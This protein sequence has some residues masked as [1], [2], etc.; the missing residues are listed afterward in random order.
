MLDQSIITIPNGPLVK[1]EIFTDDDFK[2]DG[3]LQFHASNP[4]SN[5][6]RQ[7]GGEMLHTG[8]G[9][10]DLFGD[11]FL[12]FYTEPMNPG[13]RDLARRVIHKIELNPSKIVHGHNGIP[14]TDERRFC[15]VLILI[16]HILR[17]VLVDPS[18]ASSLIPGLI[19]DC[20]THWS[21]IEIAMH[22]RDPQQA[23][24]KLMDRM[25]SP[26][27]RSGP[28]HL[29]NTTR[30]KG[31][32]V[33]IKAYDKIPQMVDK[34]IARRRDLRPSTDDPITRLEIELKGAKT[35]AF[36][37]L[38]SDARPLLERHGEKQFL[39]GFS[40]PSLQA[41]HRHYFSEL[42]AI[43]HA[44]KSDVDGDIAGIAAMIAATHLRWHTPVDEL[45]D[46][47]VELG[48]RKGKAPY[49]KPGSKDEAKKKVAAR[50][51]MRA[52]VERFLE[53]S[54][55][56]TAAE[57]LS[58]HAYKIQ[59]FVNVEGRYGA[60]ELFTQHYGLDSIWD[61]ARDPAA[62]R[63]IQDVYLFQGPAPFQP[64]TEPTWWT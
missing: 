41:I 33:K 64:V 28:E 50:K 42:K 3:W 12:R 34:K 46:L 59:P 1:P 57:L 36:N 30:L 24:F 54:S 21:K 55:T 14:I 6:K 8:K 17:G 26:R 22:I 5:R 27:I 62:D 23:V 44:K 56:L 43:Y 9:W 38:D 18:K 4:G 31:T 20:H 16:R 47:Y 58:D 32:N 61:F 45:L 19:E 29:E 7:K 2:I 49:P 13:S 51:S 52:L 10:F 15:A 35:A 63:Q 48:R 60:G 11:R 53:E 37:F 40:L 25:R 39:K